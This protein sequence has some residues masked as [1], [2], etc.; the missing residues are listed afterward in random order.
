MSVNFRTACRKEKE[1][2]AFAELSVRQLTSTMPAFIASARTGGEDHDT[3][4]NYGIMESLYY[5]SNVADA[6]WSVDASY[7]VGVIRDL[8]RN[9]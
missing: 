9:V 2:E 4:H 1:G 5:F 7:M 3:I 8:G 6:M